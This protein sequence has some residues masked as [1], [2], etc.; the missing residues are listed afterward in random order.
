MLEELIGYRFRKQSL[1]TEAMSHAS[2]VTGSGSLERFEFLGDS[3]LD[4]L[5][6]RRLQE[7]DLSHA[8]M[9]LLRTALVN[10]DFLAFLCM[11]WS[12]EQEKTDIVES[13]SDG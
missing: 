4:H 10:A 3:I 11:E 7:H 5:V 6:V 13:T 12:V 8:K 1:L 9:H 2:C